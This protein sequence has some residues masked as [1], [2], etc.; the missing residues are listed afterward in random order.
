MRLEHFL[1]PYTKINTKWIKDLKVRPET[2]KLLISK[3]IKRGI[4]LAKRY[5]ENVHFLHTDHE[6]VNSVKSHSETC[7][8]IVKDRRIFN[9]ILAYY[10]PS[11]CVLSHFSPVLLCDPMDFSPLGSSVHGILQAR[12]LEW[13]VIP[14]SRGSSPPRDQTCVSCTAGR[15]FNC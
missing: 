11:V 6:S 10:A 12:I 7:I 15:F 2:I 1:T 9:R 8:F 3:L 5:K 14:S 13:V 4:I